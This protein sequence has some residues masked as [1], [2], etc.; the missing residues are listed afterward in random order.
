[1]RSAYRVLAF[2]VA[3][4]VVVQAA[5]IVYA[6]AGLGHW[7]DEGGTLDKA[8]FE[9]EDLEFDGVVGFMIHGMNGM[10]LIPLVA[11]ILL[12]VSFFA[13]VPGGVGRAALILGLVVLQV[14]LGIFGHDV[15]A[16][17]A[18]HGINALLLFGTAIMTGIRAKDADVATPYAA[19]R[20][21][22]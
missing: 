1:M 8:A 19:E 14:A 21:A 9:S 11:L 2:L 4:L 3:G 20:T 18:L 7:V 6:V 5:A 10:M 17:G 15:P 13:K 22:V 16:L 12:I